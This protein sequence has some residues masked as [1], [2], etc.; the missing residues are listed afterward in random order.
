MSR[1]RLILAGLLA[2]LVVGVVASASATEPPAKCGG[3][4]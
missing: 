1:T 2:L 3:N 4:S